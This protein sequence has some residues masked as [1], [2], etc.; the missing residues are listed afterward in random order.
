MQEIIKH[1]TRW[2]NVSTNRKIFSATL[3][4]ASL[5]FGAKLVSTAKELVV[6]ASFGTGDAIDAFLVAFI[7]PSLAITVISGSF[8][9]AF[10]PTYVQVREQEGK[11]SAQR[12]LSNVLAW[13]ALLLG[14]A[15]IGI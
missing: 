12:L 10:I 3:V 7:V 6:A 11:T 13:S 4:I 14:A 2:S 5:T 15:T 1:W 9:A 8:N